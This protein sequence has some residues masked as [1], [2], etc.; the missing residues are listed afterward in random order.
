VNDR[1]AGRFHLSGY[2]IVLVVSFVLALASESAIAIQFH[3]RGHPSE[4]PFFLY[5]ELKQPEQTSSVPW[6][7]CEEMRAGVVGEHEAQELKNGAP[8]FS[9]GKRTFTPSRRVFAGF[10]NAQEDKVSTVCQARVLYCTATSTPTVSAS[11][12]SCISGF[13][14][15]VNSSNPNCNTSPNLRMRSVRFSL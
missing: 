5:L 14:R 6:S 3:S 15:N 13:S 2:G 9:R 7:E 12:I 10:A 8:S 1:P 4:W 11:S